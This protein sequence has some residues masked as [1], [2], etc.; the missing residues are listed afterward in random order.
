M[1]LDLCVPGRAR[2]TSWGSAAH[3]RLGYGRLAPAVLGEL[4][5]TVT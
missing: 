4:A 5:Q 2:P 1:S 3:Q